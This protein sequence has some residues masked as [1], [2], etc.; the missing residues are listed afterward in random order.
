[1]LNSETYYGYDLNIDNNTGDR[2]ENIIGSNGS[3]KTLYQTSTGAYI[4]DENNL[5][6]DDFT[7]NPL[8]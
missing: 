7:I 4:I 3:D 2:I 8:F 5:E 1:M 6:K